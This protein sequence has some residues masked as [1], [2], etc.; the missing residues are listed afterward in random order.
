MRRALK[1]LAIFRLR[2]YKA[3]IASEDMISKVG[4][5]PGWPIRKSCRGIHYAISGA[6]GRS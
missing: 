2:L 4:R 1:V 5:E 6:H 3:P